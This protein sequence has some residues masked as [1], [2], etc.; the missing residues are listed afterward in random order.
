MSIDRG[1]DKAVMVCICVCECVCVY[2]H[3]EYYSALKNEEILPF[4]KTWMVPAGIMSSEIGQIDR[5]R[6]I[7]YDLTYL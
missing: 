7:Q 4:I 5:K 1:R 6:Q 3:M 2:I